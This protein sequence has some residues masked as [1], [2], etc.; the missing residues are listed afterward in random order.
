MKKTILAVLLF[1]ASATHAQ[2][3]EQQC[4]PGTIR[5]GEHCNDLNNNL[6]CPLITPTGFCIPL[7]DDWNIMLGGAPNISI[8]CSLVDVTEGSLVDATEGRIGLICR[9]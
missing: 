6:L 2:D 1:A 9:F 4:P 5:S 3:E 8:D 7:A